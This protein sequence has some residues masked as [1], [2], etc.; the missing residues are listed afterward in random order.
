MSS[1]PI[2]PEDLGTITISTT[3]IPKIESNWTAHIIFSR[4][5]HELSQTI[6]VVG[7]DFSTEIKIPVGTWNISMF[8]VDDYDIVNYQDSLKDITIYPDKPVFIDFQLSPAEGLIHVIIDLEDF[9]QSDQVLRARV[10]FNDEV[11]EITRDSPLEPL[12]A[13]YRILP[14]SYDFKVELFTESF[15]A[16]DKIDP[17]IWQ[18]IHIEP[19]SEQTLVWSPF[20]QDLYISVD[21]YLVPPAPTNLTALYSENKVFLTWDV[22]SYESLSGHNIYW[23]VSPFDPFELIAQLDPN[24]TEFTHDLTDQEEL[25]SILNYTVASFS[26]KVTGYRTQ[27]VEVVLD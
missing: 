16:G 12:Q 18:T 19:L 15:R 13:E 11:E 27:P 4:G 3:S 25:P 23:Q 2:T 8:L 26:P 20:M 10:H 9:P 6:E 5:K 22:I 21:I 17:G 14:G 7:T 1:S 24:T